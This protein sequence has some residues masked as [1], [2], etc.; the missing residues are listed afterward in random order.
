MA[1]KEAYVGNYYIGKKKWIPALNRFKNIL[2]IYDETEYVEEAIHRLVE[3]N[4]ILGLEEEANRY[5]VLLGYNYQSSK[6]YEE[7]YRVF[8][9]DYENPREKIKK[10]KDNVIVRKFK[11]LFK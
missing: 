4:Y 3:I 2:T 1:S 9:K 5:A 7:S 11:D 6:W 8:N 10:N